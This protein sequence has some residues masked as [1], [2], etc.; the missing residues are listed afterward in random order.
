MT[1]G[2]I[3]IEQG[4]S[5]AIEHQP[6]AVKQSDRHLLTIRRFGKQPPRFIQRRIVPRGNF[7]LLAQHALAARKIEVENLRRGGG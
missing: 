1:I 7:L 3:P 2:A 4:R 6:F 5:A